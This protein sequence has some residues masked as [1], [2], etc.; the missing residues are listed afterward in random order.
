MKDLTFDKLPEAVAKLYDKLNNI[1]SL[2]QAQANAPQQEPDEL[3]TV[4]QTADFLNLSVHT[5]YSHVRRAT[6]P[7][8]K[9]ARRL[10]FSKRQLMEWLREGKKETAAETAA[11][12]DKYIQSKRKGAKGARV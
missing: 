12:V 4:E 11:R 1:E 6:I 3:L 10:Y 8:S 5:I 2:L 9:R 7:V